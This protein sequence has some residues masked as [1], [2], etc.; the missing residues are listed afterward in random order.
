MGDTDYLDVCRIIESL[1]GKGII[2]ANARLIDE[3]KESIAFD[4]ILPCSVSKNG[5]DY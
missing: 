5:R 1:F 3:A 2:A 4:V